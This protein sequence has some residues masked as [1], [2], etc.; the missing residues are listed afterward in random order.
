MRVCRASWSGATV[1]N[2]EN[3]NNHL[4]KLKKRKAEVFGP[5]RDSGQYLTR[6]NEGNRSRQAVVVGNI[7]LV[8]EESG[9]PRLLFM[10]DG[11]N[12]RKEKL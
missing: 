10:A 1:K 9:F 5:S 7:L 11:R 8:A 2:T 4:W 3:A 12:G 6:R